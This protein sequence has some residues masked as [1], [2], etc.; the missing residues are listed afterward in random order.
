MK[1]EK[2]VECIKVHN[3]CNVFIIV[4]TLNFKL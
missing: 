4:S 3:V 2:I 1:D